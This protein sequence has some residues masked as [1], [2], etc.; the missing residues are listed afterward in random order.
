MSANDTEDDDETEPTP[1]RRRYLRIANLVVRFL[2]NV[3]KL[4]LT[5]AALLAS[6]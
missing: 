2:T 5:L 3:V 1:N 6:E 4:V